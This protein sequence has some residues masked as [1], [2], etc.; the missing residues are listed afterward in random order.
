MCGTGP[1]AQTAGYHAH[2]PPEHPA[3]TGIANLAVGMG[4]TGE[5]RR[6]RKT[7]QR[8]SKACFQRVQV[9]SSTVDSEPVD[10]GSPPAF[11]YILSRKERQNTDFLRQ[12]GPLWVRDPRIW[13]LV[14]Q[15]LLNMTETLSWLGGFLR[16][17]F[18]KPPGSALPVFKSPSS[19]STG[20]REAPGH[21]QNQ[22]LVMFISFYGWQPLGMDPQWIPRCDLYLILSQT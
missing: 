5:G 8:Q 4:R 16:P 21:Y 20:L 10:N 3:T 1:P 11:V 22:V 6:G 15:N 19:T 2:T 9:C 12:V 14:P 13:S 7:L 18:R 17:S